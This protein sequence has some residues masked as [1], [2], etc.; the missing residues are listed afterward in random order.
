[1]MPDKGASSNQE[2]TAGDGS[3]NYQA[4]RDVNVQIATHEEVAK[5][6]TG[7]N[8]TVGGSGTAIAGAGGSVSGSGNGQGGDGGHAK[9]AGD[10]LAVGGPGGRVTGRATE[11]RGGDGGGG[12][13]GDV[14]AGGGGG[15][16]AGPGVWLPPARSGYEVHQRALGLPVDP[17]LAQFGRGA[18]MPGYT[19]KLIVVDQIRADYLSARS[20]M[21]PTTM[22]D[23]HSVPLDQIN[24]A[25]AAMNE[26]WRARVVDDQFEFFV[27]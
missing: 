3:Q 8:A 13:I 5:G 18:V 4:A 23:V 1:M 27:L 22:F 2:I 9:V 6:G 12:G 7:G 16:V 25:L 10:G 14:G 19:E 17:H 26:Q 24:G 15:H 20:L 11:G 21:S